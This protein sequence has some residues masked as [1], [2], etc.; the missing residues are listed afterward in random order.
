MTT[1]RKVALLVETS[2]GYARELLHGIRAW[3]RE[4]G[5]WRI[6][7]S[8]TGRGAGIPAWLRD[9]KGDG[10]IARVE[11]R[12]VAAG[13]SRLRIPVVDVSAA[14]PQA[15]F[16]RVVTDSRAATQL[17]A[18]HLLQRGLK[19]FGYCGDNRFTWS[20]QRQAFFK[21]HLAQA[22]HTCSVHT[23]HRSGAETDSDVNAIARWLQLLPKPCGILACYDVRGR[24]VLE[25]CAV[26]KLAVPDDV[27][28]IGVHND[29]LLCDLCAPPLTSVKPNARRAG[30]EAAALL[31]A[32]M[33]GQRVPAETRWIEPIG[34]AERQSTDV[35]AV[36]DPKLSAVVRFI[37]AHACEGIDISD[38]LRAVPMSRSL[39]DRRFK[40]ALGHSPHEHIQR[41]RI[42]R[43]RT[44]LAET[45]LSIAAI[46]ERTGFA[47]TEYLTVAFRRT[48][49]MTPSEYR[50][51]LGT[52]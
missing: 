22:G 2:N 27:A 44:L 51:Q 45:E 24:E 10:I 43:V 30:Y 33:N 26:A 47:H 20:R 12:Q 50:A 35:I 41:V 37:R 39:L 23:T 13:L 6:R 19:H 40:H 17:A 48:A 25:A 8:E 15:V 16:P 5:G 36:A 18:E 3:L 46:A 11:S 7:L 9:W 42:A 38:V 28:V 21:A 32:M 52:V 14:L 49:G 29:E 31:A 1:P 34:I 4:H